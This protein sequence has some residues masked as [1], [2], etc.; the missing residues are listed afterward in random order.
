MTQ[1]YKIDPN[2]S[3]I[4]FSVKHMFVSKVHGSFKKFS[5]NFSY[6]HKNVSNSK[7]EVVID[8]ES[9]ETSDEQRDTHLKSSDFFNIKKYPL[10]TFKSKNFQMN[11]N[12][13]L[14]KGELDIHGVCKGLILQIKAPIEQQEV[15]YVEGTTQIK[16]KDFGLTWHGV[17]EAAGLL[18]GDDI[19]IKFKIQATKMV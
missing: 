15:L 13:L 7:L 1:I 11:S 12:E 4:S 16:R 6:D 19:N 9:I 8:I 14:I 17:L 3:S 5:G 10:I 2:N 18:V